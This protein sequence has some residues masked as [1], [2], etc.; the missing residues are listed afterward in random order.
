MRVLSIVAALVAA[1]LLT[2]CGTI[3]SFANGCG[4]VYSGFYTDFEYLDS[5]DEFH[6]GW[7]FAVVGLDIPLSA[8]ADTVALP[9]TAFLEPSANQ[10]TGC[11]WASP[12]TH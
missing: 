4:G 9:V 12:G 7:D 1:A 3:N 2:G 11:N 6:D 8:L 10:A 5:Y